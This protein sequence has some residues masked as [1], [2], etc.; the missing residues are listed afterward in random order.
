[1]QITEDDDSESRGRLAPH[2]VPLAMAAT[3][4]A[5]RRLHATRGAL[6]A[7]AG[8][9]GD[10]G[11]QR[12][13]QKVAR[14]KRMRRSLLMM[15]SFHYMSYDMVMMPPVQHAAP[16]MTE[17]WRELTEAAFVRVTRFS[18][19][20]FCEVADAL[21]RF[22]A[23]M[24]AADGSVM[25]RRLALF[26]LLRR[27]V[28][29]DT[30]YQQARFQRTSVS[31]LRHCINSAIKQLMAAYRKLVTTFD[32]VRIKAKLVEFAEAVDVAAPGGTPWV[33]C[34]M[35]GKPWLFC[36]PGYGKAARKMARHLGVQIDDVQ[37]SF[38]NR[39]YKGHGVKVQE[40]I[41]PDG[42]KYSFGFSLRRHDSTVY[43]ESTIPE[44]LDQLF[45][46]DQAYPQGNPA[47]PAL[48]CTD[49]AYLAGTHVIPKT[50]TV[51]LLNLQPYQRALIEA[52]D[53]ANM[54]SRNCIEDAF[55]KHSTLFPGIDKKQRQALFR[56]GENQW[57]LIVDTWY[58]QALFC[59]LHT[60]CYGNQ[61]NGHT[62][63]EPPTVDEYLSNFH[64][65]HY[66]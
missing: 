13:I 39:N 18:T 31:R 59:N 64:A 2:E 10:A 38:Y 9:G 49:Q 60:C 48:C 7:A 17:P 50:R 54:L 25:T 56:G 26:S 3:M 35:D 43:D 65:G 5:C 1:M 19:T 61:T 33:V 44:Q 40:L 36:K 63:M 30:L 6:A 22:P 29:P 28:V 16:E 11:E 47:K 53:A 57:K 52:E 62:M 21:I 58:A 66:A 51:T 20:R 46:P 14:A 4:V 12:L 23:T 15:M 55:G 32:F 45:I 27:W 41:F 34:W 24:R 37:R 8:E 42:I